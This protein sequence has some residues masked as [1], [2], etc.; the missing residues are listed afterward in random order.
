MCN[1][2]E[3]MAGVGAPLV[4]L[5][6]FWRACSMACSVGLNLRCVW[7]LTQEENGTEIRT[8]EGRGEEERRRGREGGRR[9]GGERERR[10]GGEGREVRE[11]GVVLRA[12]EVVGG[13]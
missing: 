1:Q 8:E 3:V 11:G 12:V 5:Q 6:E 7:S 4:L 2:D 13:A 10:R 9:G